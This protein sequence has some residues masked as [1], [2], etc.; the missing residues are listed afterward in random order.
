[1]GRLLKGDIQ[2]L[3]RIMTCPLENLL[4]FPTLAPD[5]HSIHQSHPRKQSAFD[6]DGKLADPCQSLQVPK[7]HLLWYHVALKRSLEDLGYLLCFSSG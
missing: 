3:G 6:A 7:I 2:L 4:R 5:Q 1:M